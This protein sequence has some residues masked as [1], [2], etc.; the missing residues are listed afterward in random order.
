[1]DSI[2]VPMAIIDLIP[3]ALFFA[4]A[5]ILQ[6]DLYNKVGK[7][8]FALLTTGS[9][10][11][12]IGGIYKA[13]WKVLYA[14]N[15]CDYQI[16]NNAFFPIQGPGFML[17]FIGLLLCHRKKPNVSAL[18]VVPYT[19][20]LPF[21]I[22]QVVGLGGAQLLLAIRAIKAKKKAAAALF[23]IS[24]IFMLG[25]GYL[26]SKFDSSSKMNWIAQVT[27]IISEGA[28]LSG[29]LLIHETLTQ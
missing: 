23:I 28:L 12:L 21:I 13:G 10:M 25:M 29:V 5:V 7:V 4:T 11:V 2:S 27:N 15:I 18:A 22:M 1:M 3:V 16:I 17:F 6:K 24:F 9:V 26:G 19:S 20:N 14:L 8:A